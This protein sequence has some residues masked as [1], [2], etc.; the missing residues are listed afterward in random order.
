M[1]TVF[2]YPQSGLLN[3]SGKLTHTYA[4]KLTRSFQRQHITAIIGKLS[5]KPFESSA[6]TV[7][8]V[9]VKI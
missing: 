7:E 9:L 8:K 4:V 3:P 5:K 2:E 1:I 6:T